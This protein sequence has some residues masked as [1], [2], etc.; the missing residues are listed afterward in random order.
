MT[1]LI[2]RIELHEHQK[3]CLISQ[4]DNLEDYGDG[5]GGDGFEQ[6]QEIERQISK[7]ND[8]LEELKSWL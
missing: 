2:K 4:L 5:F 7:L 3:N 1:E 6:I 8:I